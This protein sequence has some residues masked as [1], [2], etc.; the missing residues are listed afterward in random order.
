MK[1]LPWR[2]GTLIAE[3]NYNQLSLKYTV[4]RR[5][6]IAKESQIPE[7]SIHELVQPLGFLSFCGDPYLSFPMFGN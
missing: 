5:R 1:K 2:N 6:D 3:E 4:S 7:T